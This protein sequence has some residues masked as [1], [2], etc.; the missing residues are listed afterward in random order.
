MKNSNSLSYADINNGN[1]GSNGSDDND[2][3]VPKYVYDQK[4]CIECI[5][6]NKHGIN[7]GIKNCP[8]CGSE[9]Y[10]TGCVPAIVQSGKP[11]NCISKDK[12]TLEQA[13]RVCKAKSNSSQNCQVIEPKATLSYQRDECG[14]DYYCAYD[15]SNSCS[16]NVCNL[17]DFIYGKQSICNCE[18][19]SPEQDP[20]HTLKPGQGRE[21]I[22]GKNC[23]EYMPYY[24][25]PELHVDPQLIHFYSGYTSY[26]DMP[27][28]DRWYSFLN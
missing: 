2:S 6:R 22:R 16:Y 1:N 25:A 3:N 21:C 12:Y 10:D 24:G 17:N 27:N 14:D 9:N 7:K 13:Y 11:S 26:L 8:H 18:K 4:K 28:R 15:E 5:E 20:H 23:Q 19:V